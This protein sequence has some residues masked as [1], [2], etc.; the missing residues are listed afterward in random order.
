[1]KDRTAPNVS[2]AEMFAATS[3]RL[4][5]TAAGTSGEP[6]SSVVQAAHGQVDGGTGN[7]ARLV[8]G[9]EAGRVRHCL[10]GHEPPR[11][12]PARAELLEL[13]PGHSRLRAW[14]EEFPEGAGLRH[15]L[16]SKAD[17]SD[18]VGREF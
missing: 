8:G 17:D 6:G 1:M 11:V 2:R 12:G 15:A 7:P 14:L 10:E 3:V 4:R 18:A 5:R 9:Q 13:L 16:G